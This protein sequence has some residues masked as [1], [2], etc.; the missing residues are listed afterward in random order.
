MSNSMT[1]ILGLDI[2]KLGGVNK[3]IFTLSLGYLRDYGKLA[4]SSA[5]NK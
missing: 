5:N 3:L 2:S 4:H 1:S